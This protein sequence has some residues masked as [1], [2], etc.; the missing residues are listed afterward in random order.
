MKCKD[1]MSGSTHMNGKTALITGAARGIGQAIALRFAEVG[2]DLA[3]G[4]LQADWLDETA[5]KA[6]ALGRRVSCYGLDVSKQ[7]AVQDVVGAVA[8]DF[9]RIDV[10]VNNA[11][12]TKDGFL[13]RMSEADWDAVL[14]VNLKGAFLM[15]KA[16]ARYMLK[17]R[18]GSIVNVASI[19][20]LIGNAGQCNYA[21][22][23]AG[24]I[25]LTKSTAKELASRK[26]RVNAVA[27]GFI[28]T[29][30]T[31][32]LPEEIQAKMLEAIP[33]SRFGD[34]ADVARVVLFLAGDDAAYV[35]GQVLTVCGGMVM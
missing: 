34:P 26:I 14:D 20:G 22:S 17:Q 6:R 21:A 13:A 2:A 4:D 31:D 5:G 23:K 12:I 9:E 1:G 10:L 30:M 11:G 7:D 25:A 33:L 16:V 8:R 3:L 32:K 18:A 19:I 24:V 15:T 28:R 29:A 27:P 35:T